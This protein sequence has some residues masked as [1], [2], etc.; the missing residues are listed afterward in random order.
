MESSQTFAF[1][2][3]VKAERKSNLD[4][5]GR[6]KF[7]NGVPQIFFE[8]R[9][10]RKVVQ[11]RVC[12]KWKKTGQSNMALLEVPILAGHEMD[13]ESVDKLLNGHGPKNWG[14]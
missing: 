10:Q 2:L 1:I 6:N 9:N 14:G 13:L 4:N 7:R 3:Y 11:I 8:K 12:A 5:G